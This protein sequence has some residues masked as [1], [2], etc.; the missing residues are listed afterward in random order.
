MALV[1]LIRGRVRRAFG[2]DV[3]YA[4][5]ALPLLRMVLPP[6]PAAWKSAAPVAAAGDTITVYVVEP[7]SGGQVAAATAAAAFPFGTVLL[8]LWL[9][10]ALSFAGWHMASHARFCRRLV[11]TAA[12]ETMV[13]GVHL[14]ESD[15]ASGPLAFGLLRRYVAFPRDFAERYESDERDLALAHELGHHQRGDLLANWIALAVLACHWFNPLAW[16]AFRAFRADQEIAND[17]R[18]LAG[19]SAVTRHAYACAIVKAA[20]GGAVSAACH[21]HTIEDLKGRLTMLKS[22]RPSRSRLMAGGAA[23]ASLTLAG[24]AITASGTAAAERVRTSVE[25]ATGVELSQIAAPAAPA[26]PPA[27]MTVASPATPARPAAPALAAP[28][29]PAAFSA[30][31]AT[32]AVPPVPAAPPVPPAPVAGESRSI[33]VT[34]TD[35]GPKKYRIVVQKRDGSVETREGVGDPAA[36]LAGMPEVSEQ[37]CPGTDREKM[38]R[39]DSSGGRNRIVI[40]TNHIEAAASEGAKVAVNAAR[41][42]RNAMRAARDSLRQARS[43]IAANRDM[44]AAQRAEALKGI[45]EAMAELDNE[46]D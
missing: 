8:G 30:A 24:L 43:S 28:V 41:I 39:H 34:S 9:A 19:C 23:V 15:A 40:C 22:A 14:I 21:L 13:D 12:R 37:N 32:P 35:G 45:D 36:A 4:L 42:E 20:H 1:L 26:A 7:L 44:G 16:R 3:A 33:Q 29:A 31:L 6:L 27:P 2:P 10:G 18:V 46:K 38:V 17:A 11:G 5:W 25:T